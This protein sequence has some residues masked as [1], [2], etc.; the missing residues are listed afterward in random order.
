[1]TPSKD[2]SSVQLISKIIGFVAAAA[3]GVWLSTKMFGV[4]VP[5]VTPQT[6][7]GLSVLSPSP[8]EETAII[9][10]SLEPEEDFKN[11][12]NSG[13]G[14]GI[15]IRVTRIDYGS[16]NEPELAD[17]VQE[18]VDAVKGGYGV[19][20]FSSSEKEVSVSGINGK[21]ISMTYS[22]MSGS[23]ESEWL[24]LLGDGT[25]WRIETYYYGVCVALNKLAKR[26][27]TEVNVIQ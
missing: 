1:M 18:V 5:D 7:A 8:F 16:G 2:D 14:T 13:E 23:S 15:G 27:T 20:N 19:T 11:Y 22:D 26:I 3:F 10:K 4:S 9:T 6:V 21:Q 25:V 24:I 17:A 12:E